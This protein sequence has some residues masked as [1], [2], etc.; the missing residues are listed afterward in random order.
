VD[1]ERL[2]EFFRGPARFFLKHRLGAALPREEEALLD[3]EPF[4]VT[5]LERYTLQQRVLADRLAGKSVETDLARL[6]AEGVL[7]HG[8][9]GELALSNIAGEI[10]AFLPLI[11]R[12]MKGGE[13]VRKA[14]AVTV[15]GYTLTGAVDSLDGCGVL[16]FRYADITPGDLMRAWV[17][18]LLLQAADPGAPVSACHMGKGRQ[19]VLKAVDDPEV[20]LGALL[21]VYRQGLC[22]P[23]HLFPKSSYAYAEEMKKTLSAD[24]AMQKAHEKWTGGWQ[25][26]GEAGDA[27]M[28][29]CFAGADPLD[30][31]FRELAAAVYGALLE[32]TE[33]AKW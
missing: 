28:L 33:A 4:A 9:P 14:V 2:L 16:S 29:I 12:A 11:R 26:N 7:P 20:A 10:D 31:E 17:S 25:G 24:K 19:V 8:V 21:D 22:R 6:R 32:H 13:M 23:L 18:L 5:G 1:M 27:A 30:D 3:R 15:D